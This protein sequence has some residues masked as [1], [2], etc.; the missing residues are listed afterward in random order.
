MDL[1]F[2]ATLH[3]Y[4]YLLFF[5][6]QLPSEIPEWNSTKTN[7]CSEVLFENVCPIFGVYSPLQIGVQKPPVS[8]TLQ[9]ANLT[10]CIFETNL[11]MHNRADALETTRGLLHRLQML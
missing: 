6:R 9:T 5:F 3:I 2:T 7:T 11:Y 1:G 10:A 4:L 8:T